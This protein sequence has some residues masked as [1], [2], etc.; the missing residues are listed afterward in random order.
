MAKINTNKLERDIAKKEEE[1]LQ[2]FKEELEAMNEEEFKQYFNHLIDKYYKMLFTFQAD[3]S[4]YYEESKQQYKT[5]KKVKRILASKYN[6]LNNY[7]NGIRLEKAENI[8]YKYMVELN[9]MEK[10]YNNIIYHGATQELIYINTTLTNLIDLYEKEPSEALLDV[11]EEALT[12]S[13]ELLRVINK[14]PVHDSIE[15]IKEEVTFKK[16]HFSKDKFSKEELEELPEEWNTD[17]YTTSVLSIQLK[18]EVEKY[19]DIYKK[20]EAIL[21]EDVIINFEADLYSSEAV[22]F[23]NV[24]LKSMDYE[25]AVEM[26]AYTKLLQEENNK[27]Y[28][29]NLIE[30]WSL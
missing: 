27:G 18:H 25:E 22:N 7:E 16:E 12:K 8:A 2:E 26:V 29:Y 9:S 11:I 1:L 3:Y 4:K 13:I 17:Y 23:L 5:I 10:S 20:L 15:E 24:L 6:N 14:L 19:E 28:L 21:P 30:S